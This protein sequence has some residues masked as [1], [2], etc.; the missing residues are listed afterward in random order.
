M[1]ILL[2]RLLRL[3]SSPRARDRRLTRILWSR[4]LGSRSCSLARILRSWV[5]RRGRRRRV[6]PERTRTPESAI[7]ALNS[8]CG[9]A[10]LQS[11]ASCSA[12]LVL[13]R[14]V[15]KF[16]KRIVGLI[17][18]D[19]DAF[20]AR[21]ARN[22]CNAAARNRTHARSARKGSLLLRR[23]RPDGGRGR[24]KC[25]GY[26]RCACRLSPGSLPAG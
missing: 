7:R 9:S 20:A 26:A 15:E 2:W 21:L 19:L 24:P 11:S 13:A 5:L 25:A 17:V 3:G 4:A 10:G 23:S 16:P 22:A 18:N 6:R 12:H 1:L 8:I 14:V